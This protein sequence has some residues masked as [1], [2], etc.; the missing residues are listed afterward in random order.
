[1]IFLVFAT[2]D[3]QTFL[4]LKTW[5][6]LIDKGMSTLCIQPQ[7]ILIQNKT[8]LESII[9][10]SLIT[11]FLEINPAIKGFFKTN[12]V[13]GQGLDQLTEFMRK[14]VV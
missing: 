13:T 10:D 2:N 11:K 1:M 5:L 3:L 4:D 8:D 9:D 12:C 14:E 6:N 7:Y